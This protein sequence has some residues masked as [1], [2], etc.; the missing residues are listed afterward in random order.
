MPKL[1]FVAGWAAALAACGSSSASSAS[2][3]KIDLGVRLARCMRAH[4]V[5][6]F[7][8]PSPGGGIKL[9]VASGLNPQSAS[10]QAAEQDRKQYAPAQGGPPTMSAAERQHALAFARCMRS[11]GVPS[12]PDPQVST[13]GGSTAI[14]Q[15]APASAVASPAF[16]E[17]EKAC[18]GLEP[19]PSNGGP[20]GHGPGKQVLLASARCLRAHS[21]SGFPDPNAQ[22]R[23]TLAMVSAAGVE[24]HALAFFTAARRCVGVTHGAISMAQVAAA[25]SG[26]H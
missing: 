13:S 17:A 2:T 5:P 1:L 16:K 18:A 7:P 9:T 26:R 4:G 15:V 3:A 11:H 19:G 25:E 23:L 24:V 20:D 8:D 10:F 21:I 12:F 6:N 14:R 22:G